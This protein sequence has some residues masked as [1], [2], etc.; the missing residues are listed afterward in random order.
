M[1]MMAATQTAIGYGSVFVVVLLIVCIGLYL[2]VR[3]R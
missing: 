2:F 3:G 1:N